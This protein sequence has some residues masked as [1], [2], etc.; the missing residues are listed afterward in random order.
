MKKLLG[1]NRVQPADL[2]QFFLWMA[3]QT[4]TK[5]KAQAKAKAMKVKILKKAKAQTKKAKAQTK[6]FAF[7]M[8][9]KGKIARGWV[10]TN[11]AEHATKNA[12]N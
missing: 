11:A 12:A 5:A 7:V 2:N 4:K 6:V 9:S 1:F 10:T 8:T 3:S